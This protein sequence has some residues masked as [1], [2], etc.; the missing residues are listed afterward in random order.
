MAKY[1]LRQSISERSVKKFHDRAM[2]MSLEIE[3]IDLND[4]VFLS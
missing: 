3:E 4:R 1:T 2:L